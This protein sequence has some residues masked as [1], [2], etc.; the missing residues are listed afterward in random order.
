VTPA[1]G[2][3]SETTYPLPE[4]VARKYYHGNANEVT[5][6]DWEEGDLSQAEPDHAA[7]SRTEEDFFDEDFF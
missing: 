2:I 1:F 6:A 4:K 7:S 5:D 3:T